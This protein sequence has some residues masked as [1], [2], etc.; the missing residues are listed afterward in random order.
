[1]Y[2]LNLIRYEHSRI[3]LIASLILSVGL[4][5]CAH[6]ED[7]ESNTDTIDQ[8]YLIP[9]DGKF[10]TGYYSNLAMELEGDF[11]ATMIL[12]LTNL[13]QSEREKFDNPSV[14]RLIAEKQV[15]MAKGQLN[16]KSLHLNLTSGDI[17]FINQVIVQRAE[18]EFLVVDY[19]IVAESLVTHE[20]LKEQGLTPKDLEDTSY[21]VII[22]EDPRNMFVR[23]GESCADGFE[24]GGLKESNY[25]YYFAPQKESCKIPMSTQASFHL[26]SLLPQ[27]ETFPEYDRLADDGV[28]KSAIIF[29]AYTN[30]NPPASDWGVM[31][32]RS[33]EV[34]LRITGW[35]K[36]DGLT[37]GQRY[38]QEINGIT[39]M[40]DLFSPK[41]LYEYK[42]TNLIFGDLLKTQE[43]IVYNGHSFYGSLDALEV[44]QNYPQDM[45]Q[46][47]F[48]NSC[49]SYEYYTKQVFNHKATPAD[50]SGWA[51]VDVLN[52]TTY[53]YF[54]QMSTATI[55][56][57]SNILA[58]AA[59]GGADDRGRRYSWQNII[60]IMND[61]AQGICPADADPQ[62][63]RRYQRKNKH[64]IYGVSGVRTNTF[65][66]AK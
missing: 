36:V 38:K 51:D 39:M 16:E 55:K 59:Y 45:Y 13:D 34:D 24:V 12:D 63:C 14:L 30:E 43:I 25:F 62:D 33:Y 37:I 35:E 58:G 47:L 60:G 28:V 54:P 7:E 23:A 44:P 2:L 66:P 8:E 19:S 53:A 18:G 1:M 21:A 40:I 15:K 3:S 5:A 61:E 26:R 6:S 49:W 52:N 56:F 27:Q 31:M 48:M 29:G 50:P 9:P 20:E 65:T 22:P 11:A 17:K 32:W 42:N 4:I 41:D 57:M 10:D 64:E 46:I